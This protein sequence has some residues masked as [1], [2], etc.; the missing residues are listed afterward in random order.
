MK[1]LLSLILLS[2]FGFVNA[3]D[4]PEQLLHEDK[5]DP[6]AK[7]ILDKTKMLYESYK[8]M[9]ANF[10]MEIEIPEEDTEVQKG[11]LIQDGKKFQLSLPDIQIY[12]DGSTV[13]TYMNRNK[14]VQISDAEDIEDS[15]DFLTPND[16]LKM[17]DR[18][19]FYYVLMNV[20]TEGNTP[21]QQ[22]EFKP[23]DSDSEYSKMRLTINR[24]NAQ[25]K[26]I[27]IFSKDGSRFTLKINE[28]KTNKTYADNAFKLDTKSLPKDVSVED[29]RI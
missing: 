10:T 8:T 17:Y 11:K 2:T 29:L 1:Y 21:I 25:I 4:I 13:W 20:A 3:Q 12:N 16:I 22:I 14:Q 26:R 9:E 23:K 15:E 27:K 6:E 28:L 7:A 19:D 18:G 5:N 24:K